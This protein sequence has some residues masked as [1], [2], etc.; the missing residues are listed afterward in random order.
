MKKSILTYATTLAVTAA[1]FAVLAQSELTEKQVRQTDAE[2]EI[3]GE[4]KIG[5]SGM[6][7]QKAIEAVL[8]Q[9]GGQILKAEREHEDGKALYEIKGVDAN[10]KRYKIYLDTAGG[11]F[12]DKDDD[13]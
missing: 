8:A 12:F 10:G 7:L 4:D 5:S 6:T 2:Y 3:A 11:Q 13:D 1:T 9:R